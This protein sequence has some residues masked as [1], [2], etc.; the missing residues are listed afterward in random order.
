MKKQRFTSETMV[1]VYEVVL[2]FSFVFFVFVAILKKIRCILA[3]INRYYNN[4][5]AS[6]SG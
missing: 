6:D 3:K 4:I 1:Q 2:S 5:F